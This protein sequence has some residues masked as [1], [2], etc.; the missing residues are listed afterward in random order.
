[1]LR[2]MSTLSIVLIALATPSMLALA[3]VVSPRKLDCVSLEGTAIPAGNQI[4]GDRIKAFSKP[5]LLLFRSPV[6]SAQGTILLFPGGGY[7]IL[8]MQKE[9]ENTARFLNQQGFDVA[10][11]EYH[12]ASGPQTRDLALA[13]A[14]TAFRLLKSK[15]ADLA[16]HNGHF[17]IMGYSA[18]GH[19]AARTVQN[20][21]QTGQ[22]DDLILGYPAYLQECIPGTVI[23][24]VKPPLKPGRLFVV[25]ATNDNPDWVKSSREYAKI[26][27]GYGGE[28]D[29]QLLPDG[30]HGFGMEADCAA[31][32]QH[33]PD[34]LKAFLL[35]KPDAASIAFNPA[36]MPVGFNSD[37]PSH[38][39]SQLAGGIEAIVNI[40]R[41]NVL[42]PKSCF[43][44]ASPA[45][46]VVPTRPR[47]APYLTALQRSP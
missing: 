17:G 21:G 11:L 19:L 7:S 1:M 32:A 30:G 6:Q 23:T 16:L 37:P 33:W 44:G 43:C 41:S 10:L 20:L 25:I 22:P 34:L 13:D 35:A 8:E 42:M 28:I 4:E 26:W 39:A 47:I 15:A 9:G 5:A 24:S 27:K 38:T 31:S 18:G 29:Y 36:V 2:I 46:M 14:V 12:V 40:M 45:A 3:D